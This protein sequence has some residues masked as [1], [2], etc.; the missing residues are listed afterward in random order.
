MPVVIASTAKNAVIAPKNVAK[1]LSNCN[2][3][4]ANSGAA[5]SVKA[6]NGRCWPGL[7]DDFVRLAMLLN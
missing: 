4:V 2:N 5:A 3:R 1:E 6:S 7:Y